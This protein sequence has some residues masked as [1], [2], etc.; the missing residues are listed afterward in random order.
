MSHVTEWK[1]I[2]TGIFEKRIVERKY[3]LR[4]CDMATGRNDFEVRD[5]ITPVAVVPLKE[6]VQ[7]LRQ[8]IRL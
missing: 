5:H 6:V 7:Y 2:G 8:S 4:K 3:K 1:R